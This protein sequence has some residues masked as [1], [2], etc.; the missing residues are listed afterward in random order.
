MFYF[1]NDQFLT[2]WDYIDE[3]IE[4]LCCDDGQTLIDEYK[5]KNKKTGE[6]K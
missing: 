5:R 4:F 2:A 1:Y 3:Y 6:C